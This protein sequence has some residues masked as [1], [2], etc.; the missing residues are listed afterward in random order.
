MKNSNRPAAIRLA[1]RFFFAVQWQQSKQKDL[2]L[3]ASLLVWGL[4]KL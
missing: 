3:Q 2:L 4:C 1:G